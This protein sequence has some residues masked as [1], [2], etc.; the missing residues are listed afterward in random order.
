MRERQ[1]P[2]DIGYA[3]VSTGEQNLDLQLEA[4]RKAGCDV[5]RTERASGKAGQAR[6]VQEA[7][8]RELRAGDT[9]TVWKLDRLGRSAMDLEHL[10]TDLDR[11]GVK[12]RAITQAIDT[13]SP[14]GWFFFQL[15]AAF[16]EL[17]RAMIVERTK[18][19]KAA[20]IAQGLHPG[21]PRTY[22]FA[23]DRVTVIEDEAARINEAA[24]YMLK[25]GSLAHVVA[26]W[27][28][29]GVPSRSGNGRWHESTLRRKLCREDLVPKILSKETHD[30]LVRLFA[31]AKARQ[32]IGP[33]A[34]YLLSG[35]LICECGSPMYGHNDPTGGYKAY[36]CSKGYGATKGSERDGCGKTTVSVSMAD[37]WIADAV[38]TL[39]CGPRFMEAL[40]ARRAALLAGEATTQEL[41]DWEVEIS[42][43]QTILGTRFAAE[44]HRARHDELQRRLRNAHIQLAARPELQQ[45]MD[46][47]RTQ[48]AF[49]AAWGRWD[50]SERRTKIKLLLNQVTVN[51][52]GKSTG[53]F[54]PDRLDPDWKL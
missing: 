16:A 17:E 1:D 38:R 26:R 11:R 9:L 32:R 31:P 13:S 30:A 37:K 27:N 48:E 33:R 42:E 36:R 52:V 6:P 45:L 23:E 35:I 18:A 39:V 51:A 50:V 15:L 49:K 25:G 8:L 19:G 4:L 47:P 29:L 14:L 20:R 10:V 53:R 40:N 41:D 12:F 46:F 24:Q 22:G 44:Q 54:D 21:G 2:M 5:I 7:I 28:K 3:R 43:L 34:K